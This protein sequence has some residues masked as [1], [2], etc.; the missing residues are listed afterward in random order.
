MLRPFEFDSRLAERGCRGCP[1]PSQPKR[2]RTAHQPK[3]WFDQ[4]SH[5]LPT[6]LALSQADHC[7]VR[8]IFSITPCHRLASAST[9]VEASFGELP[10]GANDSFR[11]RSDTVGLLSAD[12]TSADILATIGAG[13]RPGAASAN[14]VST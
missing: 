6:H 8:P 12:A 11:R 10:T 7:A 13:V 2:H 9:K 5:F 14:H 3:H 1:L 4:A